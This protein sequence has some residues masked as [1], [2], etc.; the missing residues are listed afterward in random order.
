MAE[1]AKTIGAESTRL[2]RAFTQSYGIAPHAYVLG[3]RMNAARD[4]IL[5][6]QSLADVAA[7]VG[8]SDQAHLTRRFTAFL[9]ITPGRYRRDAT[10]WHWRLGQ[11]QP[12]V[13]GNR[14]ATAAG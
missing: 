13:S 2:A 11:P 14:Q 5:A 7:E 9:G 1:A 3:R 10:P 4:R 6:G 8:F 12:A